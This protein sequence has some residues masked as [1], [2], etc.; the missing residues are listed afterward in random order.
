[1]QY[2]YLQYSWAQVQAI[3]QGITTVKNT[4]SGD[5]Y[6]HF[7]PQKKQGSATSTWGPF[8]GTF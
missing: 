7:P 4:V 6:Y 8:I 3:P 2:K 1:M 5:V